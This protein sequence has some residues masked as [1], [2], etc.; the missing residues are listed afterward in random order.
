MG[1]D[2]IGIEILSKLENFTKVE[3]FG[4]VF[5]QTNHIWDANILEDK[6]E[7]RD[8]AAT[9]VWYKWGGEHCAIAHANQTAA[10]ML[11]KAIKLFKNVTACDCSKLLTECE[12]VLE[13]VQQKLMMTGGT[14][15]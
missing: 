1:I 12:R 15:N 8:L 7:E 13:V 6:T 4:Q 9:A 10:E 3:N 2:E 5:Y 11:S 14:S